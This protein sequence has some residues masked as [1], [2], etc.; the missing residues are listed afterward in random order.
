MV[1]QKRS[2]VDEERA[3]AQRIILKGPRYPWGERGIRNK[4]G[5]ALFVCPAPFKQEIGRASCRER[6]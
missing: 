5:A 1:I 2:L 4:S 6:V 3:M